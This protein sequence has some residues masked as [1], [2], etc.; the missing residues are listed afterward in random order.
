MRAAD[1]CVVDASVGI[2]CLRSGENLTLQA[3]A[4]LDVSH[5]AGRRTTPDLFD[6]ECA[7]AL[8]KAERR[9]EISSTQLGD[10]LA[11]LSRLFIFRAPV[12]PFAEQAA[13]LAAR[14]RITVYDAVYV[15]LA[16]ALG[17]PLVTADERLVR[18][19]NGAP[20]E[21]VRLADIEV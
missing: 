10:A 13:V 8:V 9:G 4:L 2:K 16:V 20:V 1:P 3:R 6:L 17:M 21:M 15:I 12:R 7:G 5:S 14:R 19:M 11:L 18:A